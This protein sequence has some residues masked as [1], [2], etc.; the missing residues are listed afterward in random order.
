MILI[1]GKFLSAEHIEYVDI[2]PLNDQLYT[3][4]VK[5]TGNTVVF[6]KGKSDLMDRKMAIELWRRIIKA[7]SNYK[8]T[9]KSF[10]QRV[11]FPTYKEVHPEPESEKS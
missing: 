8:S 5:M 10:I 2:E 4:T 3:V 9:E 6:G 11:D 1:A 7:I